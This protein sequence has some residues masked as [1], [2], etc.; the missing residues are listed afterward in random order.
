MA[1]NLNF[2]P[3]GRSHIAAPLRI[4][5][6]KTHVIIGSIP[7]LLEKLHIGKAPMREHYMNNPQTRPV[8]P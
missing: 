2:R 4:V 1:V 6:R 5:K 8:Q 3:A 7:Y